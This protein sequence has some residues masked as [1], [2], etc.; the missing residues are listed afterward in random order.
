MVIRS[1]IDFN[2][3]QPGF[4]SS[5]AEP[6]LRMLIHAYYGRFF[7]D[8]IASKYAHEYIRQIEDYI[9]ADAASLQRCLTDQS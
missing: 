5:G 6:T 4:E 8:D 2:V 7:P 9:D 3:V 1:I